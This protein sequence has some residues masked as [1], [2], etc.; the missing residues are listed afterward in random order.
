VAITRTCKHSEKATERREAAL[1]RGVDDLQNCLEY[2]VRDRPR[3]L[4]FARERYVR[5]ALV[6]YRA[7]KRVSQ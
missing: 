1:K 2:V 6:L 7:I 3:A 5:F 4:K